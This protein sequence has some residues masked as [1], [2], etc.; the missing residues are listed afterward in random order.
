MKKE[1]EATFGDAIGLTRSTEAAYWPS[2]ESDPANDVLGNAT[3]LVN[4][5]C[6]I[7]VV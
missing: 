2:N 5:D 1:L 6:P 3:D 4:W 7:R